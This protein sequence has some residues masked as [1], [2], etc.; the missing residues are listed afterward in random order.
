MV[1]KI[2]PLSNQPSAP[3][4]LRGTF[5]CN[6]IVHKF[7][8]FENQI[9]TSNVVKNDPFEDVLIYFS[10]SLLGKGSEEDI[11]WDMAKNCISKLGFEE[12]QFRYSFA[13]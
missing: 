4:F 1:R 8:L 2:A 6:V 7:L 3:F 9:L 12:V 10:K 11:L 13:C 5:F